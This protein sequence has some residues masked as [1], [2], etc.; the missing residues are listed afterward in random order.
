LARKAGPVEKREN[1]W[2]RLTA[3]Q[4]TSQRDVLHL[5]DL[6]LDLRC[7]VHKRPIFGA[8]D[9]VFANGIL[10]DVISFLAMAFTVTKSVFKKIALPLDT[11]LLGDAFLPFAD[12]N[13]DGFS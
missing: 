12:D 9:E 5:E 11:D 8:R 2:R 10:Q 4:R 6:S 3:S 7:E 1:A 13:S